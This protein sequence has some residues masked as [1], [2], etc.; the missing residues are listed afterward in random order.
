MDSPLPL[1][2]EGKDTFP[3]I[4]R[5][6]LLWTAMLLSPMVCTFSLGGLGA[7]FVFLPLGGSQFGERLA[8]LAFLLYF[9]APLVPVFGLILITGLV[10][11]GTGL[12]TYLHVS[13]SGLEYRYWPFYG[14][15]CSWGDIRALRKQRR[16]GLFPAEDLLLERGRHFGWP[17]AMTLRRALGLGTGHIIPLRGLRGWP[18]GPL[19]DDIR[20]FAPGLTEL[21]GA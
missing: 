3:H 21:S 6:R 12:L 9:L 10:F 4:Y 8:M 1:P 20:R 2:D 19:S 15:R 11:A 5:Y 14:V 17:A 13:P 16:R 18:E 7:W